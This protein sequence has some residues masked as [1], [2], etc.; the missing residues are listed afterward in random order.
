[1]GQPLEV[2]QKVLHENHKHDLTRSQKLQLQ[3]FGRFTV[4]KLLTNTTYQIQADR[5]PTITKTVHRNHPIEHY[6]KEKT[7]PAM[8]EEYVPPDHQNDNL[9]DRLMEKR[10]RTLNNPCTTDEHDSLPFPR[11]PFRSIPSTNKPKQLST[12][13]NG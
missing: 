1:M 7:L 13:S 12:H 4:T 6:P 8:I 2:A 5:D 3:R 10:A 11:E 9:Y